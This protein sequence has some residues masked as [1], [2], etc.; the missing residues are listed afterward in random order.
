MARLEPDRVRTG[1]LDALPDIVRIAKANGWTSLRLT[2]GDTFKKAAFLAAAA[3][4]L[5]VENYTPS[6]TVEVEGERLRARFVARDKRRDGSD[7]GKVT[8]EATDTPAAPKAL[9]ERFLR[10]THEE[11]ARDPELRRAQTQVAQVIAITRAKYPDEPAKASKDIEAKRQEVALRI[12]GGDKIAGIQ[13]RNEQARQ[14][15]AV[16]QDKTLQQ[17]RTR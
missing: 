3:Q 11:N 7:K 14:S 2:G 15:R 12:A 1:N 8:A 6:K 10:Q 16:T 9:A 4:G 17:G 13:V 5:T